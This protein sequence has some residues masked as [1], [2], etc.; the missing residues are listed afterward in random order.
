MLLK[1]VPEDQDRVLIW[2]PVA[3]QLNAGRAALGGHHDQSLFRRRIAEGVLLLQEIDTQRRGQRFGRPAV[4]LARF[5]IVGLDQDD[6]HLPGQD[7]LNLEKKLL[8]SIQ[9]LVRGQLVI[10]ESE[11]IANHHSN[12]GVQLQ[13]YCG[14]D[15][16]CFS[17]STLVGGLL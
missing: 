7:H 8:P 6:K 3:H 15:D 11:L 13:G 14:I 5:G 10:R 17:R 2:D 9:I 12:P 1:K 4:V 16:L